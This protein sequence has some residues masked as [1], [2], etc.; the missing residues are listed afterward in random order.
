MSLF[1]D[2]FD[3]FEEIFKKFKSKGMRGL[4]SGYSI[5]ITYGPDG[6]PIINVETYGDVDKESLRR[7]LEKQYPGAK[8]IGLGEELIEVTPK[9]SDKSKHIERK[10][11]KRK[12]APNEIIEVEDNEE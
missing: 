11:K 3:E 5:S 7:E 9:E 6:K 2:F 4:S 8:I 12:L 10:T 1:D